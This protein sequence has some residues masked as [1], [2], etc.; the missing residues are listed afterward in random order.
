LEHHSS[1][2]FNV[3][4]GDVLILAGD[5]IN[6]KHLKTNGTTKELYL[7]FFDDCSKNYNHV[8]YVLGNHE[9]Y[10][11]NYEGTKNK[12]LEFVPN[13]FHVLEN[14]TFTLDNWSFIGFTLWTNFFDE[15]PFEMMD[16]QNYMNDYKVIRI[17]PNFRK[18]RT[19]DTLSFNR[20][21]RE[22]LKTQLETLTNNI[23]V[24][25]HHSPS[26]QSIPEFYKNEK[27]NGAYC[28]NMDELII[29]NPQIKYFVHGHTHSA[30][31]YMIGGCR[32]LCNPYGYTGEATNFT[33]NSDLIIEPND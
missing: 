16:A 12:I 13:N 10:G 11:Y 20:K 6:A 28:N 2:T 7:R 4:E 23:F 27:C 22:Y 25:S 19:G 3:G 26:L 21:S 17:G 8:L 1:Y 32:V 30:F 15:N 14:E 9:Y 18:L 31:D 29:A 5:I 24:I 33:F